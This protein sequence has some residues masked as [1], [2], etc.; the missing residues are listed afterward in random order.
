[1]K[2]FGG[3]GVLGRVA[4]A[5]MPTG[6]AEAQMD[7]FIAGLRQSSSVRAGGDVLNLIEVGER[8]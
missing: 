1:M 3:V 7:P 4:A 6:E 8:R 2:V 5:N